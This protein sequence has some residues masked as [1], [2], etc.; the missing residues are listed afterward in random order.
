MY[1]NKTKIANKISALEIECCLARVNHPLSNKASILKINLQIS[2]PWSSS[3]IV[4]VISVS[5]GPIH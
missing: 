1:I 4:Y 5:I 2:S 3:N